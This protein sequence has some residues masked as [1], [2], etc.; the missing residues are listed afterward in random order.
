MADTSD[1]I[2]IGGGV[3]GLSVAY[4]LAGRGAGRVLLLEAGQCGGGA[5]LRATGGVRHQF[6][7]AINV[8]LSLLA[9][10]FWQGFDDAFS[11]RGVFRELG[12]LFLA[13]TP[14]LVAVA[15]RNV[16]LQA[17]L[18][19]PARLVTPAEAAALAPGLNE[20]GVLAGSFCP[21]DGVLAV[22]RMV[23]ALV[24]GCRRAGVDLR[25]GT[26]VQG[27]AVA[28]G[29]VTGVT[30]PAGAVAAPVVVNAAGNQAAA[31]G[32]L[33]GVDL[34]VRPER[35]QAALT[36]PTA[37]LHPAAAWTID[38]GSGGYVRPDA[39]GGAVIGGGDRGV[40]SDLPVDQ[41]DRAGIEHARDL[42]GRRFPAL[43]GVPLARA[44]AGQR[45]MSPDDHAILG[46]TA[47]DGFI[48]ACGLGSHGL[49]HAPAVGR[50]L[51][52][53]IVDGAATSLD[54]APL[55]P[56]RFATGALLTES[57]RF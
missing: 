36:V 13:T 2:V 57:V 33:A 12:Y 56:A 46:A 26:P 47:V 42:A 30:I 11:T 10:P 54:I 29:R 27:I 43:A 4:H 35:R 22:D 23:G 45:P 48:A 53:L 51:A 50:L 9:R 28:G 7:T 6:G 44:W 52:E 24:A 41:V 5:T 55:S 16:A 19:V 3:V 37:A 8:A 31:V 20:G 32:A 40:T 25:E 21:W 15:E 38:L 17:A 34:P 14:E 39:T 1:V 49:M 18:G